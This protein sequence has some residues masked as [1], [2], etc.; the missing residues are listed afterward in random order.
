MGYREREPFFHTSEKARDSLDW[1][2]RTSDSATQNVFLVRVAVPIGMY[3]VCDFFAPFPAFLRL[4]FFSG[5]FDS[6]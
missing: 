2:A 1:A 3:Q 4:S 5:D 6:A